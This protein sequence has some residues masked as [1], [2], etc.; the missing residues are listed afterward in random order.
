MEQRL[1]RSSL[2]TGSH[3]EDAI[4]RAASLDR[5]EPVPGSQ[6]LE[7]SDGDGGGDDSHGDGDI[8]VMVLQQEV[9]L[10]RCC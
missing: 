2:S 1:S 9:Y 3:E 6:T 10:L 8:M 7:D 5:A 4:A